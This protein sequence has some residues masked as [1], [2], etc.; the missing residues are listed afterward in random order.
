MFVKA[1]NDVLDFTWDWSAWMPTGD[2]IDTVTWTAQSGITIP[3]LTAPTTLAATP[4]S[5]GGTLPAGTYYVKVTS[6]NAGG[7]TT[8]SNEVGP[9]TTT[10]S[11]SS[12][13]LTWDADSVCTGSKIYLGTTSGS[14]N[15]VFTQSTTAE[16]FTIT[17]N[18]G[19]AGT[20]PVSNTAQAESQTSNTATVFISGGTAGN[21]YTLT[22]QIQTEFGRVSQNTQN[23]NVVQ[24]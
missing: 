1:P 6:T 21:T 17:T 23:I 13:A 11:T 15:V 10:G 19:T 9:I 3:T 5:T 16:T 2:K 18:T 20:P 12:I 14:E 8:A 4:A 22:C 24:L 7:E